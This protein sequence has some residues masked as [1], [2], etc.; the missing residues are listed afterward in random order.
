MYVDSPETNQTITVVNMQ[1]GAVLCRRHTNGELVP[2]LMVW[3]LAVALSC[4]LL[5]TLLSVYLQLGNPT[6]EMVFWIGMLPGM[7]L[8]GTGTEDELDRFGV[9][10]CLTVFTCCYMFNLMQRYSGRRRS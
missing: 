9:F 7:L 2:G 1:D 4:A 5:S 8:F 10:F 6:R 3:V